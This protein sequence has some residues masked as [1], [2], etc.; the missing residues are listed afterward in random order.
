MNPIGAD[1]PS[2]SRD[3]SPSTQVREQITERIR[4]GNP[5]P[6]E[7]TPIPESVNRPT[8]KL[9]R[10]KAPACNHD[11]EKAEETFRPSRAALDPGVRQRAARTIRAFRGSTGARRPI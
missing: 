3:I 6:I 2:I 7:E 4:T 8:E 1:H 9:S 10:T 5:E 11:L